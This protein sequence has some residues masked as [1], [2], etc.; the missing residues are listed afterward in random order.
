MRRAQNGAAALAASIIPFQKFPCLKTGCSQRRTLP[1]WGIERT[2][3]RSR[4]QPSPLPLISR[5]ARLYQF[6]GACAKARP[7]KR[8]LKPISHA[9]DRAMPVPPCAQPRCCGRGMCP[10]TART[11]YS[12]PK[13]TGAFYTRTPISYTRACSHKRSYASFGQIFA[14]FHVENS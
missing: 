7:T 8:G 9:A 11:M 3:R 13:R 14:I 12:W 2:A 1:R 5:R 10:C 4:Q 6:A